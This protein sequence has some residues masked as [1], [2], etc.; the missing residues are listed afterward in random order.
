MVASKGSGYVMRNPDAF[1]HCYDR[2][3]AVGEVSTQSELVS[4]SQAYRL[5]N[6]APAN[7]ELSQLVYEEILTELT[8]ST[9]SAHFTSNYHVLQ[10]CNVTAESFYSSQGRSDGRF[11]DGNQ[12][13]IPMVIE[14]YTFSSD[15]CFSLYL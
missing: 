14:R 13:L 8:S 1:H 11:D 7:A 5:H 9:K 6:I 12:D 2:V 10:G 4:A 3:L 15:S